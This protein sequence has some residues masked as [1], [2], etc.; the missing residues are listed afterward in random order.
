MV[1]RCYEGPA[2]TQGEG[3]CADGEQTCQDGRWG[4]CTDQVLPAEELCDGF[5]DDCDGR[6]D[7]NPNA[8]PVACGLGA[9]RAEGRRIC[10]DEE[11]VIECVE[12]MP[13][14][15]ICDGIDNDCDGISDEMYPTRTSCAVWGM[16]PNGNEDVYRRRVC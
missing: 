9:C 2:G 14:P 7:E 3:R 13:N 4:A 5:D 16:R 1:R 15:E 11:W 12:G 6:V 8:E 10:V